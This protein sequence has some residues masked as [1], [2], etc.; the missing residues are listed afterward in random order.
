MKISFYDPDKDRAHQ[1]RDGSSFTL[2][3][4]GELGWKNNPFE[5]D[6][7]LIAGMEDERQEINLFFIKKRRYGS[8]TGPTGSGKTT[9]LNWL[10]DELSAH[11]DY[12]VVKI[13]A[14]RIPDAS[15]LRVAL[16]D[17]VRGFFS[18]GKDLSLDELLDVLE[19]KAK[20]HLVVLVD[21][22]QHLDDQ[23]VRVLDGV[24]GLTASVVCAGS[25]QPGIA[26]DD[27]LQIT[28]G[29]RTVKEYRLILE[30]RIQAVGGEGMHPFTVSVVERMAEET[31]NTRDFLS[32][33]HETAIAIA[34]KQV[35][36]EGDEPEEKVA[37]DAEKKASKRKKKNSSGVK[38]RER[39]KYDKLIESLSDELS[40]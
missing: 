5:L 22:S 38:G 14:S 32:L 34:L 12:R 7:H 13:D 19:Q 24:L 36:L 26:A 23:Q 16:A 1:Q 17:T 18:R 31:D 28:L 39:T 27:S 10:S 29:E 25:R 3:W 9:L 37:E 21:D 15:H 35:T 30:Q 11:S 8:I 20:K 4:V 33:A 40:N 2:D 6:E